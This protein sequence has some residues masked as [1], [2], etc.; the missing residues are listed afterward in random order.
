MQDREAHRQRSCVGKA[1]FTSRTEAARVA[2]RTGSNVGG[3]F[4][5]YPCDFGA[6][7]HVGHAK[8]KTLR[9][10][11]MGTETWRSQAPC[12]CR[13]RDRTGFIIHEPDCPKVES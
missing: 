9:K 6:H 3:T 10:R 4:R 7:W 1:Q 11:T 2:K 8:P 12:R 13:E 5:P